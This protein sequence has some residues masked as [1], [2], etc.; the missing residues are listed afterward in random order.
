MI[1]SLGQ[2][3]VMVMTTVAKL[4]HR[5]ALQD[6]LFASDKT[7]NLISASRVRI[8]GFRINIDDDDDPQK[9]TVDL[10]HKPTLQIRMVE[11]ETFNGVFAAVLRV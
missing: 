1:C 9:G 11:L 3:T 10:F 6:V 2:V 5:V 8:N 7:F 4:R